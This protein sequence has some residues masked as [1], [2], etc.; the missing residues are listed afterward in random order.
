M[1]YLLADV[2]HPYSPGDTCKVFTGDKDGV[3][4]GEHY[5]LLIP[6]GAF[7]NHT[8]IKE[9]RVNYRHDDSRPT[10][11]EMLGTNDRVLYRGIPEYH[12]APDQQGHL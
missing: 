2:N 7:P 5:D 11:M 4:S 6:A 1:T 3:R 8:M 10:L 9:A 12:P